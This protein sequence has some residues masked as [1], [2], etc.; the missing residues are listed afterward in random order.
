MYKVAPDNRPRS[1]KCA[2]KL[3]IWEGVLNTVVYSYCLLYGELPGQT[4][5]HITRGRHLQEAHSNL[6]LCISLFPN[7]IYVRRN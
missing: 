5:M 6:D 1:I 7:N 4:N 3:K 2:Q